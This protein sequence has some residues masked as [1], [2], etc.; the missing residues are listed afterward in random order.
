MCLSPVVFDFNQFP[1]SFSADLVVS[2]SRMLETLQN[3]I[4]F[5]KFEEQMYPKMKFTAFH[6][7]N[8][9]KRK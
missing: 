3:E 1:A 8:T 4:E 5:H 7:F 9:I 2:W 6:L